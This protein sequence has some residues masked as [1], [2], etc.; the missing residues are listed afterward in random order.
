MVVVA[1]KADIV[2]ERVFTSDDVRDVG[3]RLEA[4][5]LETSAKTDLNVEL[6]F[7]SLVERLVEI[8]QDMLLQKKKK[9][10]CILL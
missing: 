6:A 3:E 10:A 1:N 8:H 9:R 2:D 4:T 7:N 5:V